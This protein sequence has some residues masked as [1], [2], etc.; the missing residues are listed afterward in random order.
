MP[1]SVSTIGLLLGCAAVHYMPSGSTAVSPEAQVLR[2]SACQV[3]ESSERSI[4]LFGGKANAISSIIALASE[5][6]NPNWDGNDAEPISDLAVST[7]EIFIRALPSDIPLPEFAP[8]PDGSISLDWI[9]SRKRLFSV[10]IGASDRLAFAWIDG[11]DR[12]HGVVRF[13]G[14]AIPQ[15]IREGIHSTFNDEYTALRTI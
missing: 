15:K 9:E 2:K 7:A 10:S 5:C 13:D 12:G 6:S 11:T 4:A 1:Q 8:D 14:G 3:F